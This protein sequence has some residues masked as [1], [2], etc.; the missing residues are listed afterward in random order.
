MLRIDENFVGPLRP[1][2]DR[3]SHQTGSK[4]DKERARQQHQSEKAADRAARRRFKV[5]RSEASP[6]VD[7]DIA[8]IVPGPQP[9]LPE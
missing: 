8:D 2:E 6:D 5:N 9:T 1:T 3:M 7:P 4:R